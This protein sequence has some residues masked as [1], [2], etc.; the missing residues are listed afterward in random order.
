MRRLVLAFDMGLGK[1]LIGC[2][3][4]KAFKNT[5]SNMKVYIVCPASL[6]KEWSRTASEATGLH[7]EEEKKLKKGKKSQ[8]DVSDPLDICIC[9]WAK[10]P[11]RVPDSIKKYIVIGDEAHNMQSM[12]SGRTKNMLKLVLSKRCK[13]VLLLTGTP[14]K[15]GKPANLFPLLRA[16]GHP[17]GDDQMAYETHF[18][19]GQQKRVGPGCGRV[20]WDANGSSN[21][22]LLN[23][24]ISSHVVYKTKE[25]CLK[26][27]PKKT[28]EYRK[29]PVS[30]RYEIQH[31]NAMRELAN[32]VQSLTDADN[33]SNDAVLGAFARVRQ[34]SSFA[35]VDATV[36]LAKCI[37]EK[38][39]SV[40]I[41]T[42]FVSVAKKVHKK[43]NESGWDGELLTGETA[44]K[45][46]QGIVDNFQAG[47]SPV[48]VATFGAGGV[49][50]TLTAACTVILLDR[51]WTPGDAL[52]AED[53]VRRIGQTRPVTSIWM[54]AFQVDE[55]IDKLIE[56]KGHNSTAVV[57]GRQDSHLNNLD[58]NKSASAPK[59]SLRQ[60][61]QSI[62]TNN[63]K[64]NQG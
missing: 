6:K 58:K 26:E 34:V 16:T 8:S 32:I 62:V 50:I 37:L 51:P 40:V 59:V 36:A 7:C 52:Q 11:T 24:H 63:A 55:Q 61:V 56:Q 25:D 14:M 13:G 2:V 21:L 31:T 46:R 4:A 29:V 10:V 30:S 1:T 23:A 20:V 43:L 64:N 38:E 44:T 39:S 18:C 5:F 60:L 48:F 41:F 3:W 17:F 12:E 22:Q 19:N 42:F 35:K 28:R 54:R 47:V 15:N 33:D 9:S 27:L 49:G 53:R 45:K 57:V